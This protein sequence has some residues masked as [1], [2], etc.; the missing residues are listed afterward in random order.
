MGKSLSLLL[1]W[2]QDFPLKRFS[3]VQSKFIDFY[4]AHL[5]E[6][7]CPVPFCLNIKHK[8][9][10]QQ[11]QQRLQQAQL[12]RRRMAV[13]NTRSTVPSSALPGNSNTGGPGGVLAGGAVGQTGVMSGQP[14]VG[15][16]VSL[17]TS[18][19]PAGSKP[20]TQTPPANVLQVVKQV[21]QEKC[22]C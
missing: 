5:Q 21:S 16:M 9:K 13:M 20:G 2:I 18:H 3:F 10:Q 11:L 19:Q 12:L 1:K 14:G 22:S 6:T 7:K 8:L 15:N 17:Q 4:L